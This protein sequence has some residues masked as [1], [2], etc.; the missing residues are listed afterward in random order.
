MP[1]ATERVESLEALFMRVPLRP[2]DLIAVVALSAF[3]LAA[4]GSHV[5]RSGETLSDIASDHG[6]TVRALVE[7]NGLS[8]PNLIVAGQTLE[9]PGGSGGSSATTYVVENG[10]TLGAIAR[11]F[12]TTVRALV[13]ANG[14]TNPN[15]IRTGSELAIT[16][17]G[18][19]SS[20]ATA[21][22]P[23][24]SSGTGKQLP[25]QRHL[26]K[27]GETVASI[28]RKY[29]ISASDFQRWNG[30]QDGTLYASTSLLLYDP[31]TLPGSGSSAAQSYTVKNGDTLGAIAR[32]FGSS[33]S[34]I[35]KATGLASANTIY[36]GQKLTIPGSSGSAARC[37]VPGSRFI[38]GWGFARS[39]GRSHAGIDLFA[40]MGTPVYA[41]ASGWVDIAT[42]SIG[43]LQ[44]RL[45][46][47]NGTLWFGSHLSKFGK[48]GQ[49]SAGDVIGYVGDSGNAKGSNPHLHFEVHPS[50]QAVNPYP[51][52]RSAC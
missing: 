13:E 43:G 33:S 2:R 32:R 45:T 35:A 36:V 14:I 46:D 48:S 20:T 49:V 17:S 38:N 5:V 19:G 39:G 23:A 3:A 41:P 10:D 9:I 31:G 28:A 26:V 44:F 27:P 7:S 47:A 29:G 50:G 12:G 30:L 34:A 40:P 11:K 1:D 42:G 24:P 8:D 6:T 4:S 16:G 51:F 37:P 15:L 18:S 52:L 25:G 22:A 21:S